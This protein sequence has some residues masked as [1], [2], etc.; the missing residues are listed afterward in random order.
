MVSPQDTAPSLDP[1]P[2]GYIIPA[3]DSPNQSSG[4]DP[5]VTAFQ[6]FFGF[7]VADIL[8]PLSPSLSNQL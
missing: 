5:Y 6:L 7:P 2:H 1:I 4:S 8:L 3:F